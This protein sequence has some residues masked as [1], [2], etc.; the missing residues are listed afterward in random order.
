MKQAQVVQSYLEA[1]TANL[2]Q[3]AKADSVLLPFVDKLSKIDTSRQQ[4]GPLPRL[5]HPAMSYLD[6][7]LDETGGEPGFVDKAVAA[8]RHLDWR[9]VYAG[10][11]IDPVLTSGMLAAQAV[12]DGL[13]D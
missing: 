1:L 3:R 5:Q 2:A 10:G 9:Q 8:V 7:A 12:G 6:R 11:G 13:C 4:R